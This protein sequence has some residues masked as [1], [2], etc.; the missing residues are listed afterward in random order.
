METF[1]KKPSDK[2]HDILQ[3]SRINPLDAIFQPQTVA[4]IGA[5]EKPGS[6][7]RTL[8]WNLITNP[9]GGTVFPINLYRHSVL[10]IKAYATIFDVPEK[11]DLAVIATPAPTVP[12]IISD[13]VDAGI[14]GA[15][16]I[17]AGFKESGEKGLVLEQEILQQAQG[18]KIRIIGPNCLGVMNPISGLNATFASKMA[19]PGNVG[20]ISQSGALCTSILDWSLKENVG[21]SAFISIGSMLDIGWGDLIYYLGD[22]PQTKSIVIYMESIGNARSFLSAAREVALTKPIIVI[23]AGRTAAAAKAAVSHTGALTGSDAVLDAAFRRC[24]VLRVNSISDLFDMSEVLAKQPRPQGSRLTILTNAG[25]PGVLAT[26][27]LIENGGELATISPETMT[28]LNEILPPQWSHNNPIDI[29]GDADPQR[30]QKALEIVTKDAN[31]DGLLVILTP[32]SMTDPTEIAVQLKA[33]AQL[34]NKPILAS[35]MGG[36]DVAAGEQILN[37]QGIPTYA[38]PDAAARVFSYM[39]KSSYNLRGIYETPVL[40]TL[41]CDVN[42]R[43]CANIT[44]IMQAART[45]KRTILTEFES[46]EI[47]AAYG[48]PVVVGC[49]AKSADQAVK[50]AENIGYPVV[51][52]L[53]SQTITHKT[54]VGGVQLNL[55]NG[56]A[57]KLA[58][59]NIEISVKEKG[60]AEDFLG[61]TVQPMV[62][63]DG[64]ELIIGSSLDPQFGPVLL[65]GTGG[66][67]VEIFQ[68]SSLALPPLNTTLARRM[69][70]QTKI[71]Q[72]LSG[73]RG[74]KSINI[75]AL[76][77]LMVEFSQLVIE[78]PDIKEIDINPLLAFPPT[79]ENPRGLIALDARI[80]LHSPDLT[81]NQLPKLAIRPYPSQY[82]SNWQLK[83]GI[84]VIIRPIRPEDEPLMVEFHKTLSAESVYF[85][86][87]HLIKLSQRIT[88]ERLTRMCFIDY[89]REMALVAEYQNPQTKNREILAVGRLSKS[90]ENKSAEFAILVS[91]QFQYQGL[92]TELLS[93]LL[94]VGKN[95]KICCIYADILADNSVMQQVCKKLGF[96]ISHTDDQTVL[97]SE[98]KL[99]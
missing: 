67:L 2:A 15:I 76:E 22:D 19:R 27:T 18:G 92:G 6:V 38:Y 55:Q 35:W 66:Q 63:T 43:N 93:K 25:G 53:Y 16:I 90:H 49:I 20:F 51:L 39:W 99:T 4:V 72:A 65:F 34:S 68:D 29:L 8:L 31:S 74:R 44:N 14:K 3:V 69:M 89:D 62:K 86:Y 5:T 84:P 94:E 17:S 54:D 58:Y 21:F 52:K 23:K 30:Y 77:Q 79:P 87:F 1:T 70:E 88:H 91:D 12:K 85:R 56:E 83:N 7:G 11:I 13:C 95:E 45:A 78:Q 24:G 50:C 60:K 57:V 73:V 75:S 97:R 32:Q 47:L 71:Y 82:I 46:K 64:Y 42:T 28:S 59:E 96:Q 36:N 9:F 10:G 41:I 37:S 48:I 80:V 61:V 40:P 33:Y 26:D 81:E 98:I